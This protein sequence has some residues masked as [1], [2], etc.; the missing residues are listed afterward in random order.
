M[1]MLYANLCGSTQPEFEQITRAI[2][3]NTNLI[4]GEG[5]FDDELMK[6]SH[7]Q[8]ISKGGSEGIQC[9]GRL[10]EGIGLAIKVEDGSRRAKHAVALHLLKQLEWISQWG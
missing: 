5:G 9:L 8:V 2:M 6:R 10:G 1:A 3:R 4:S 7:L